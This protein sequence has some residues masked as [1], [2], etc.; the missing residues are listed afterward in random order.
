MT[1]LLLFDEFRLFQIDY[2]SVFHGTSFVKSFENIR[3]VKRKGLVLFFS[4]E[5]IVS[6]NSVRG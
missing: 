4:A 3:L 6:E 5:R 2:V 1:Y